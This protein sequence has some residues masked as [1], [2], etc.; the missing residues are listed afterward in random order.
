MKTVSVRELSRILSGKLAGEGRT[1]VKSV[2]TDTR[3]TAGKDLFFALRGERFDGHAFLEELISS[4][5]KAAVVE[6]SNPNVINF[7]RK[8]PDF[9]LVLVDNS[10][11]ALGELASWNRRNLNIVVVGI[12]GSTGKTCTKDF[13]SSVLETEAPAA[14]SSGSYNNEI[15]VPLT[16]LE[17]DESD[18]YLVVEMGARKPGDIKYLSEIAKPDYGVITN[19]GVT[20]LELFGSVETIAQTKA[21]LALSLP[22][23]GALVLNSDNGWSKWISRKTSARVVRF[24]SKAGS[25]YRA[26][27]IRLKDSAK[28]EFELR[29]P[30]FSINV[31]LG[32]I[33][34]H[35]IENALA[36]AACASVLGIKP[37]KI[38][39][40]LESATMASWRMEP[41]K[42]PGGFLIL[43]DSYNANPQSMKAALHALKEFS[44]GRRAIAVL[45]EMA[46]LGEQSRKFHEEV[47]RELVNLDID[48]IV[49]IGKKAST[50]ACM[51]L[52][53]GARRGSVFECVDIDKAAEIL[54]CIIEQGDVVL[55]K[56][57]RIVGLE[58]LAER[59][60]SKDFSKAR[61]VSNG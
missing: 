55:L 17:A 19:I 41:I 34:A 39:R 13:L 14:F 36:A 60:N 5:V 31:K 51:A 32:T 29:G 48:I 15:G 7:R 47:G 56:G 54:A 2:G 59:L 25:D 1:R 37:S 24:G 30:D 42:A 11:E 44:K 21:E 50:Y 38:G 35:Q 18:K 26:L 8:Y 4:G 6:G 33:G 22:R 45:G 46:E 53:C 28:P 40:G 61:T 20:H 12:T 43:N 16:I 49:S 52:V 58:K 57:S 27:R 9:P 10:I 23:S 3:R